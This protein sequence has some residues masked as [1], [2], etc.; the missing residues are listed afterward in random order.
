MKKLIILTLAVLFLM[1][2]AAFATQTRVL[3]MGDNHVILVDDANIWNWPSRLNNY[4]DL[5]IAEFES[6]DNFTR[7]GVHWQFGT[8]NPWVLATY[9][10]DNFTF[11][12]YFG[13]PFFPAFDN[14]RGHFFFAKNMGTNKFGARATGYW[15]GYENTDNDTPPFQQKESFTY[16]ELSLGLTDANDGWDIAVTGGFGS[17]TDEFAGLPQSEPD[18]MLDFM[19]LGRMFWA[20]GNPNFTYVP[21][22]GIE[23]HK[24][25]Y[26]FF[27]G[28]GAN[29]ENYKLTAFVVQAGIG[30]VYTPSTN[31]E[32]VIDVGLGIER[33]KEEYTDLVTATNNYENKNNYT[34]IPYFKLGLDAGVFDWMDVRFGATNFWTMQK[35]EFS[36]PG[37]GVPNF[38]EDKFNYADNQT[39]LGFGFHWG[40]LHVDTYTD[41]EVFLNGFDFIS[42]DGN[43]DMNFQMSAA[44]DLM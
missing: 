4:P 25:G 37:V 32:A 38:F 33:Y 27:D 42:G 31:V 20:G 41:P 1:S 43:G 36:Q 14:R 35:N 19:A 12:P 13:L 22:A 44:Y 7:F 9:F 3:T 40:N 5:A 23:Y 2:A 26:D 15:S 18:G 34:V 28:T 10:E 29:D 8:D 6:S 30:Q 11:T 39:Y 24:A 17:F 21:H 16:Y